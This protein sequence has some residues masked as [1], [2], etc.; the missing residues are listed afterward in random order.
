MLGPPSPRGPNISGRKRKHEEDERQTIPNIL[1][2]EVARLDVKFLVNLDPSYCS[3]N[4]TVHLVCKLGETGD[5]RS[6]PVGMTG[7][8]LGSV[9]VWMCFFNVASCLFSCQTI[10]TSPAFLHCSSAFPPIILNRVLTGPMT[11]SST[12]R[13]RDIPSSAGGSA[14]AAGVALSNPD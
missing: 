7:G 13:C 10:K 14:L 9:C 12:V 5:V 2:G 6:C 1:Q 3:N 11:E 8:S 4:G